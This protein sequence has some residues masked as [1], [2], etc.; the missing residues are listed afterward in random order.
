[1]STSVMDDYMFRDFTT[2]CKRNYPITINILYMTII[3]MNR[4]CL[5]ERPYSQCEIVWLDRQKFS[6]HF[7]RSNRA[8]N[9]VHYTI[10]IYIDCMI[11]SHIFRILPLYNE[12]KSE[13]T[14]PCIK[15]E[16][17]QISDDI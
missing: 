1:M 13:P 8:E 6:M 17:N 7:F 15:L 4:E 2:E 16:I 10:P 14:Q 12:I 5:I 3:W 9:H 11:Y